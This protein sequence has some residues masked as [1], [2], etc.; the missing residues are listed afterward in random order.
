[1]LSADGPDELRYVR[2]DRLPRTRTEQDRAR[3]QATHEHGGVAEHRARVP[4]PPDGLRRSRPCA[5]CVQHGGMKLA[6]RRRVL[7][8][9]EYAEQ[10][11]ELVAKRP[12]LGV[13]EQHTR[14]VGALL[15]VELAVELGMYQFDMPFF[16]HGLN[17]PWSSSTSLSSWRAVK[18]RDFTVFSGS[19][20]I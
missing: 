20:R 14:E 7:E 5:D 10:A 15:G 9:R 6:W 4:G 13:G 16:D 8:L 3:E 11:V 17:I 1:M 19:C 18:S 12:R 2:T